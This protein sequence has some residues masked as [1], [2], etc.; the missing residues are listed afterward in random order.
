MKKIRVKDYIHS[1]LKEFSLYDNVRSIPILFDGFKPSQRKAIYGTLNRGEGAPEIQVERLAAYVA[2][3]SD[4]HHGTGS[5]ESTIVGLANN[6]AGSNN[7]NLLVPSGQFGSRLTKDAAASRYIFTK[8]SNNFRQLFRKEDDLILEYNYSDGEKIEPKYYLPILPMVLVNGSQGT[9]T[10]H[11]SLIL[12]YHPNKLRDLILQV[13]DNK[14]LTKNK[15]VPWFNGFKGKVERDL[16]SGQVVVTGK[17][18]VINTTT[19][20]ISEIPVGLYHDQYQ[21]ILF[22]LEDE[23]FIK[24]F[25]SRST[26]ESFDFLVQCPRTTTALDLDK[27]YQKFKL[28]SRDTENF[29]LWNEKG[30]LERF[31]S[32]ESVIERFVPWR[33]TKYEER[34]LKLIEVV[35]EKIRILNEKIRF[36]TFYLENVLLFRDTK[37]AKL[38]EILLENK[39]EDYDKLLNLPIWSLTKDKIDELKDT[40]AEEKK[41]L[42]S[43]ENTNSK[44]MYVKELNELNLNV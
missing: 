25:D 13:L 2:E 1:E 39:F 31:D 16:V 14:T 3:R 32:A 38:I 40:L 24:S 9:G 33:L 12:S 26:E 4:Y 28:I 18:E 41:Y 44:E 42:H 23:G 20:R 35:N 17:L 36:I 30:T 27:L 21:E 5:M 19:I 43:L 11:A 37:K 6:Y 22:K 7:V 15:L 8:L 29:T 34:R 10:G